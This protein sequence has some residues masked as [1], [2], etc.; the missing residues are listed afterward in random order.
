MPRG[1]GGG[2]T[3]KSMRVDCDPKDL[4]GGFA[5]ALIFRDVTD[6]PP[7]REM[8]ELL[9]RLRDPDEPEPYWRRFYSAND[10]EG[11]WI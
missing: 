4:P 8:Q 10:N 2:R 5:F 7:P 3:A 11:R 9:R 6:H 1:C